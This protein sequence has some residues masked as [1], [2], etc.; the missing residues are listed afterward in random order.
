MDKNRIINTAIGLTSI[1]I[2]LFVLEPWHHKLSEN[3]KNV[4]KT[5]YQTNQILR[6]ERLINNKE[7][8]DL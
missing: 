5:V 2:Q 4:E 8:K 1:G 6:D 3:I 7:F